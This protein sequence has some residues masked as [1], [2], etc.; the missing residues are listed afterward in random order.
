[1][2]QED[3]EGVSYAE[4]LGKT[5]KKIAELELNKSDNAGGIELLKNSQE[6]LVK[7]AL[8]DL[9]DSFS[10]D[11]VDPEDQNKV[12]HLTKESLKLLV[13]G[14][15]G[16]E[17][18]QKIIDQIIS[19][20]VSETTKR[21]KQNEVMDQQLSAAEASVVLQQTQIDQQHKINE[22]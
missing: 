16:E 11:I 3:L 21:N 14:N 10:M 13:D 6:S 9:S 5:V 12:K 8:N 20:L 4:V 22:A 1:M 15:Q 19:L 17:H 2:Q 18:K 7:Q